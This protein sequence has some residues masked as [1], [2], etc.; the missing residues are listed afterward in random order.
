MLTCKYCGKAFIR[1]VIVLQHEKRCRNNPEIVFLRLIETH[2]EKL[3]EVC[4]R[5]KDK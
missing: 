4:K 3:L 2:G 1:P 5:L